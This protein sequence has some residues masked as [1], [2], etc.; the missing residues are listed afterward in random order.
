[1]MHRLMRRPNSVASPWESAS[2]VRRPRQPSHQA[3][4]EAI[5]TR[6][7]VQLGKTVGGKAAVE[8]IRWTFEVGRPSEELIPQNLLPTEVSPNKGL[9]SLRTT[10]ASHTRKHARTHTLDDRKPRP[11]L[12]RVVNLETTERAQKSF[13]TYAGGCQPLSRYSFR[14]CA[15]P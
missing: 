14:C 10:V 4:V 1:M 11:P 8:G 9:F 6:G 3:R 5:H 15:T 13:T 7:V 12:N 2:R